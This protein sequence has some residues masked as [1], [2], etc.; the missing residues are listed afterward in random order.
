MSATATKNL[1]LRRTPAQGRAKKSIERVFEATKRLLD[2][3]GLDAL[4]TNRIAAAADVST[5]AIYN[6]FPNKE[7]ILFAMVED[8]LGGLREGYDAALQAAA[9]QAT[10]FEWIELIVQHNEALYDSEP[11]IAKFYNALTIMPDL[12]TLDAQHDDDVGN[13]MVEAQAV[14]APELCKVQAKANATIMILMIHSVLSNS[15]SQN[16][17]FS[18]QMRKELRFCLNAIVAKYLV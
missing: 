18:A 11:I 6:F 2:N 10:P 13:L 7:A 3:G 17:Q 4:N 9:A 8:W 5:G 14:F 16:P 1:E 15:V 12:R